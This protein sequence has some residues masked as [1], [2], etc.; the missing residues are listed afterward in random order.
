MDNVRQAYEEAVLEHGTSDPGKYAMEY[1]RLSGF[2][3]VMSSTGRQ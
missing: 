1:V 3:S 2:V